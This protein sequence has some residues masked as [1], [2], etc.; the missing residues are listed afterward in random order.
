MTP[1]DVLGL[2]PQAS[3]AE[4]TAA[5]RSLALI[6]HPDRFIDCSEDVRQEAERRMIR[7]NDAYAVLKRSGGARRRAWSTW[8][9]Q[10]GSGPEANTSAGGTIPGVPWEQSAYQRAEQARRAERERR[11]RE[12]QSKNGAAIERQKPKQP[13]PLVVAGLGEALFTNKFRCRGCGSVQWLPDGWKDRLSQSDFFCSV[14]ERLLLA[15]RPRER[16]F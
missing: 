3:D 4:V 6:F 8:R 13:L 11:A 15:Y 14:C 10:G 16:S 7:L 9:D 2:S 1:Y 12:Q 5:Y